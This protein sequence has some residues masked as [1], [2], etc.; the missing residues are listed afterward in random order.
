M[1][2]KLIHENNGV[3]VGTNI[4]YISWLNC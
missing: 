1:V 4:E 2:S 3:C